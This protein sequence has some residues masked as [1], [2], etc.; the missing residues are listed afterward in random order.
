MAIIEWKDVITGKNRLYSQSFINQDIIDN[1]YS[2]EELIDLHG[3]AKFFWECLV[4]PELKYIRAKE[5]TYLHFLN[6]TLPYDYLSEDNE[7]LLILDNTYL[8]IIIISILTA[9]YLIYRVII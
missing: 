6:A 2:D 8:I 5:R 9:I 1:S 4:T 7:R 3:T